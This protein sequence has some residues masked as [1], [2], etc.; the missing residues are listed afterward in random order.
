M[1][2]PPPALGYPPGQRPEGPGRSPTTVPAP[3][4]FGAPR[5]HVALR[6]EG[7]KGYTAQAR[8]ATARAVPGRVRSRTPTP[9]RP[10]CIRD[11]IRQR[12][13]VLSEA[14]PPRAPG[15][16]PGDREGGVRLPRRFLRLRKV[17]FPATAPA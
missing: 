13:Q 5:R 11:P 1:R 7:R 15:R 17:D 2:S 14:E 6:P 3:R 8:T 10:W 4:R 12:L 9:G 16:L